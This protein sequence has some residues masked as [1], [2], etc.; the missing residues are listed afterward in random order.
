VLGNARAEVLRAL[1]DALYEALFPVAA[2]GEDT[3]ITVPF[4]FE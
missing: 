2:S 1:S 4:I 3:E